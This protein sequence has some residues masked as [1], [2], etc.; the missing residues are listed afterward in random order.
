LLEA[1]LKMILI[2]LISWHSIIDRK[3]ASYFL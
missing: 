1:H 3:T 2:A